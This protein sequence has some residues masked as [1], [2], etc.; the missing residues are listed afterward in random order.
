[1]AVPHALDETPAEAVLE[2]AAKFATIEERLAAQP[3][4]DAVLRTLTRLACDEVPGADEAG[5]TRSRH[6]GLQTLAPTGPLVEQ[7]D[8]L[9]YQ[10]GTGPCLAAALE[11]RLFN[12]GDLRADTRW[13]EFGRR[14]HETTGVTSML[15]YR[16]FLEDA[17]DAAGLNFYS[18]RS[19]A[20]DSASEAAALLFATHGALALARAEAKNQSEHLAVALQNAREIGIAIGVLMYS[21]KLTRDQAFDVL[22]M[23]SQHTQR[24]LASI[25]AEVAHTG[26]LP[27]LLPLKEHVPKPA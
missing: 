8:R 25:A 22:R 4:A 3:D 17:D 21:M 23:L 26:A 10:L 2:F 19:H 20:F 5:I 6:G 18:T 27:V 14:A 9:Q 16:F 24:K 13:P 1:M 12:A 15:S 7:V 11:G